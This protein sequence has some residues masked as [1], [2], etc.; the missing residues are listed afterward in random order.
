MLKSCDTVVALSNATV[1]NQVIF[2]K[3]AIDQRSNVSR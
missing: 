1:D 3:T 2:G